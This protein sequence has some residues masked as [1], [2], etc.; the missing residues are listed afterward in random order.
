MTQ[1]KE[2]KMNVLLIVGLIVALIVA[3]NV[4]LDRDRANAMKSPYYDP[5]KTVPGG[6]ALKHKAKLTIYRDVE[7]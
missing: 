6:E 1:A 7:V 4:L 2:D 3:V 5:K